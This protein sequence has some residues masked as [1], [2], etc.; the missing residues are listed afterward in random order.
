MNAPPPR[1]GLDQAATT[2]RHYATKSAFIAVVNTPGLLT[3][4]QRAVAKAIADLVNYQDGHPRRGFAWPSRYRLAQDTG[5]TVRTVTT[6][7]K[8][9]ASFQLIEVQRHRGQKGRGGTTHKYALR[10][11]D[12][13]EVQTMLANAK[14][15]EVKAFHRF[16]TR[17]VGPSA[18]SGEIS[19]SEG[20]KTAA[21]ERKSFLPSL[22][23]TNS[24]D[25]TPIA[26]VAPGEARQLGNGKVEAAQ[27]KPN[28]PP[29][30]TARD[31]VA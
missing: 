26:P 25:S 13:H 20:G 16:E 30:L 28:S 23:N 9:L 22:S 3:P 27:R 4:G 6:A 19:A 11:P 12:Q 2:K 31:S 15:K 17:D 8:V 7:I 21:Q 1:A 5:L 24:I 14:E 29:R 18:E 10:V